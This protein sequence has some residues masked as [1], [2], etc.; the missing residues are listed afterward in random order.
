MGGLEF[1]EFYVYLDMMPGH[2]LIVTLGLYFSLFSVSREPVQA[3]S[4]ENLVDAAR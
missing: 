4:V 3:I 2:L 1:Q